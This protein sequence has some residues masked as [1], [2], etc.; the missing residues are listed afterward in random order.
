MPKIFYIS[1][2]FND[3]SWMDY[4]GQA[5]D[6]INL[7]YTI[8]T[9]VGL[10]GIWVGNKPCVRDW[11]NN[12]PKGV[13]A[14]YGQLASFSV[15]SLGD[16]TQ[17][18]NFTMEGK[19][20]GQTPASLT[21]DW[22]TWYGDCQFVDQ[23]G[24][25]FIVYP[26]QQRTGAPI[27]ASAAMWVKEFTLNN[28][29]L[30]VSPAQV[31]FRAQA[32][33]NPE[34]GNEI[35]QST[36]R[37]VPLGLGHYMVNFAFQNNNPRYVIVEN[38]LNNATRQAFLNGVQ[39]L[40]RFNTMNG[41]GV[42]DAGQ[43]FRIIP[44]AN[45]KVM[46]LFQA[47]NTGAGTNSARMLNVATRTVGSIHGRYMQ[48]SSSP[49]DIET[50]LFGTE[51]VQLCMID[52]EHILLMSNRRAVVVE[53]DPTLETF[54]ILTT[55]V[56][57]N[58]IAMNVNN[59]SNSLFFFFSDE[60]VLLG[61]NTTFPTT[62]QFRAA[63]IGIKIDLSTFA[64]IEET[65]GSNELTPLVFADVGL[66]DPEGPNTAKTSSEYV[67]ADSNS[68]TI[69]NTVGIDGGANGWLLYGRVIRRA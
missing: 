39:N 2:T 13:I 26:S 54:N 18:Q 53:F 57:A 14:H 59:F 32:G 65:I 12:N 4:N 9:G 43:A 25:G 20:P 15:D 24:N 45:N 3:A 22:R 17:N 8:P 68:D 29:G 7:F 6:P 40:P 48:G 60:F 44:Y 41:A 16:F 56:F 55:H 66:S 63:L 35:F 50:G 42:F 51:V 27:A 21:T 64:V 58:T 28:A 46:G 49:L 30:T 69:Y 36:F 31:M 33:P 38:M 1:G 62:S 37:V 61:N 10:T 5:N 47:F 67:I 52:S 11:T 34:L 23:N 19:D